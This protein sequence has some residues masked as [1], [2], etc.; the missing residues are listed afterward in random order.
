[1]NF[2]NKGFTSMR[3]MLTIL[4]CCIVSGANA[5]SIL[6]NGKQLPYDIYLSGTFTSWVQDEKTEFNFDKNLG[7]YVANNVKAGPTSADN[8]RRFKITGKGWQHQFGLT[9]NKSEISVAKNSLTFVDSVA[10]A[11]LQYFADMKDIHISLPGDKVASSDEELLD[12]Y[13]Q[14][15]AAGPTPKATLKVVRD[16]PPLGN[17][18]DLKRSSGE[19]VSLMYQGDGLYAGGVVLPKGTS[20]FVL[21]NSTGKYFG[22]LF[23]S[24]GEQA[25]LNVCKEQCELNFEAD[26]QYVYQLA[27]KIPR[28]TPGTSTTLNAPVISLNKLDSLT[29][30]SVA[31][32]FDAIGSITKVLY[33]PYPLDKTGKTE[34][35][36]VSTKHSSVG[37]REFTF[38]STQQQRDD[39]PKWRTV[40]EQ[41]GSPQVVTNSP[42]FDGLF[43]LSIEDMRMNSVSNIRDA[44]YNQGKA[45]P[46]NCFETGEKWNYVWTRDLSYAVNLSLANLDPKRSMDSMLFKT[47]RFREGIAPPA[48][49]PINTMQIIQDTGSGGSWPVSTDRVSWSVAAEPVLN[50]LSGSDRQN[51][52]KTVYASLVG[53]VE[54]DRQAI[55]DN[56]EGLYGGEQSYLDWRTQTYAPWITKNLVRMSESKALST[57]VLHYQALRL[58]AKL[59]KEVGDLSSMKRYDGW[60]DDLRNKINSKFWLNDKGLY[61]S[62]TSAAEDQAAV[63]KF[64]MLGN[65]L[66]INYGIASA[67]QAK[68]IMASYPHAPFGVPVYY[69]QQPNVYVYHNRALWPFVTAYSL[70]AAKMTKNYRAANNAIN[71]LIRGTALNLSNMENLEWLTGKP[72][73]DDGPAI[74]SRRQLWSTAGYLGMVIETLFGYEVS[75]QGINISPFLTSDLRSELGTSGSAR[76]KNI[77]YRGKMISINLLLPPIQSTSGYYEPRTIVLNGKN[78]KGT[79]SESMLM[80]ANNII[81][82]TFGKLISNKQSIT[83]VSSVDPMSHTDASV[84]SPSA[85]RME[86]I[87]IEDGKLKLFFA[88]EQQGEGNESIVYN[89]YRD[90]KEVA[91][92]L[93]Q[94]TW[95]DTKK[96]KQNIR[97]CF[98]VEAVFVSSANRSHHSEPMCYEENASMFISVADERVESNVEVTPASINLNRAAL[99]GWGKPTDRL[100]VNDVIINETGSYSIQ[101]IY[102]NRQ[103]TIDS[104]VTA[105]V[106]GIRI[107]NKDGDLVN[108]GIIQMPNIADK[109]DIFP[110]LPSSE[111]VV[112]LKAGAYQIQFDDFFNMSYLE[113]NATYSGS[114]GN[115]GPVNTATIAGVKVTRLEN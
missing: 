102:N 77:N 30:K 43:A 88:G 20:S 39:K 40:V 83:M 51:F 13:L 27:I 82:V 78:V 24:S 105:A 75:E 4:T 22:N 95:L 90:G 84:F 44:N 94:N 67:D 87:G 38:T 63:Y 113:T 41:E 99:I 33:E 57:N 71:S 112:N 70:R 86:R 107:L 18:F 91:S 114:G 111:M 64:D 1:M 8:P 74:N 14:V 48:S 54:A 45:I 5:D 36:E 23:L 58:T 2:S 93:T 28:Y 62:L 32:H 52:A 109:G 16:V 42:F 50:N 103:H 96:F 80:E 81:E 98:A 53:T 73:Y 101:A 68:K 115:S 106:K 61:S 72:W 97:T 76:L 31:P 10:T 19:I 15:Q 59:A 34:I 49:L 104:G 25:S 110:F 17:S 55:Y 85:P 46:C 89:I 92:G 9:E 108:R 21:N 66:A 26:E 29:A 7:L 65:S 35:V 69:P 60:A 79:I 6:A 3:T 47:S 37:T 11:P 100:I 12:F 56:R